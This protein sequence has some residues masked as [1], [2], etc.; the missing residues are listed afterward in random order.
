M[1][2]RMNIVTKRSRQNRHLN[3]FDGQETVEIKIKDR[4]KPTPKMIEVKSANQKIVMINKRHK[5]AMADVTKKI[6]AQERTIQYLKN[7]IDALQSQ[8][9]NLNSV[10]K[11]HEKEM[12]E[13]FSEG[14]NS[15][16][17]KV[18]SLKKVI[19]KLNKEFDE[20]KVK[21]LALKKQF[22]DTVTK[23]RNEVNAFKESALKYCDDTSGDLLCFLYENNVSDKVEK[24]LEKQK[25]SK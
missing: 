11:N 16:K 3:I 24:D 15:S 14:Y 4:S 20:Y 6:T 17:K 5:K 25:S 7:K 10:Q 2:N 23:Q 22:I 18:I 8:N 13:K 12:I 19:L 1:N 9:S 21:S